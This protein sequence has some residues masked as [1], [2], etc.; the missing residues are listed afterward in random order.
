MVG[1][2]RPAR[3][4]TG[5]VAGAEVAVT[6]GFFFTV[7]VALPRRQMMLAGVG[8][9]LPRHRSST[10]YTNALK[11]PGIIDYGY[12]DTSLSSCEEDHFL[13]LELGGAPKDPRNLWPEPHA[14]D[15]NSY[16]PGHPG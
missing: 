6:S 2:F 10:S 12:T 4:Q 1:M 11:K 8:H 3:Q 16:R 9:D 15:E 13:P 5:T 7:I 14:G